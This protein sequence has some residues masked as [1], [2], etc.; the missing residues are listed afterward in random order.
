MKHSLVSI[1]AA[2]TLAAAPLAAQA[3]EPPIPVTLRVDVASQGKAISPLLF[4]VFFED[5]NYA[6]DGGLYA[7][8]VQNRSF[9]YNPVDQLH[10]NEF[11]GWMRE[12]RGGAEGD[13]GIR[14]ARP[15]NAANPHYLSIYAKTPGEGFGVS[16]AG[17]D[18]MPL[19]AGAGYEVS[20]LACQLFN[21]IAWGAGSPVE[22]HPMPVTIRLEDA[23]GT[24]LAQARDLIAGREWMH[25][26]VR[27]VP[28]KDAGDGRLV[29]LI[30]AQGAVALDEISLMPEDTFM[31]RT[32]GLR[33]D[34]AQAI[35]DLHPKFMRFPGGCL[36]HG[37]G[38]ANF[39][40]W[41]A[42]IG[43]TEERRSN[44]N[45]WGYHQSLG[46]GYFEYFQFCEDIGA[47]PLPVLPAGVSCQ[48]SGFSPGQGQ[49]CLPL[50]DMPA[51]IQDV[52]DLV[53]WANGP[54]SS[55]WGAKRAA[56][57]HPEPFGLK[58]IGIGN[59]D[60]ITSGFEARF[61]MIQDAIK[62]RYPD[63]VV[64]GT[65]GPFPDGEDFEAGW[66]FARSLGTDMVDEH[67]YRSPEWFWANLHRYDDYD[68][69][70]PKVY[71][72]EYAAH[73]PDRRNTLRSAL[74]EAAGCISFENNGDVVLMA[75]YAP[76]LSR[77]AHTQWTP[78][79]IYFNATQVMPSINYQVQRLFG[80]NSGDALLNSSIDGLPE[81][82]RA[83]VSAVRDSATG[84]LI[85]K[86]VNG[87]DRD[88]LL[89]FDST[90][91]AGKALTVTTLA[92]E[93]EL[94]ANIDGEPPL[95]PV[96]E[97]STAPAQISRIAPKHSLSIL[98]F[99]QAP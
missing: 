77:R 20:F 28:S 12:A 11:T 67:Y 88:L 43:P 34:L 21:G 2:G 52:L 70:G 75:S 19:A 69:A 22:G 56:A 54:A 9:D 30:G 5:L 62:A 61:K 48:N 86:I 99:R 90:A 37:D 96:V 49:Q 59:E 53:E 42:S 29:I 64:I 47:E 78:D 44:H 81:D 3:S 10:W 27:L 80:Q 4:G 38:V 31:G 95:L 65:V 76:L 13:L 50:E 35:A 73:E 91:L 84:D 41:K 97:E 6:A 24:V 16:N 72:G 14:S 71:V 55:Q 66:S 94:I 25:H 63:I 85:V 45:L 8:L 32:N 87:G 92:G 89:R 68:R 23:A 1:L 60:A 83:A 7:E 58:Y 15:V 17:Y 26:S 57:G 74:A 39:Y 82:Y 36:V 79:M 93:D 33:R 18:G 40:D 46:L 98:R 51:Y